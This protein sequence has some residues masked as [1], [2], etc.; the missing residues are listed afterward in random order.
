MDKVNKPIL[1]E[2]YKKNYKAFEN[3][4]YENNK[5][6][7]QKSETTIESLTIIYDIIKKVIPDPSVI[8]LLNF[9]IR[10]MIKNYTNEFQYVTSLYYKYG[11]INGIENYNEI[12]RVS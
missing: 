7:Q 3:F 8:E 2:M 10:D 12:K 1:E 6:L 9:K 11:V 5:E 4:I